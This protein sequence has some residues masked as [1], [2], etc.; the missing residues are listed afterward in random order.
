MRR[1]RALLVTVALA[2]GLAVSAGAAPAHAAVL[3]NVYY[4]SDDC[5]RYGNY[6][7]QNGYWTS[8]TCTFVSTGSGTPPYGLWFLYA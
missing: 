5:Y 3:R 2:G 4:G 7:V 8:F 1:V 6:G